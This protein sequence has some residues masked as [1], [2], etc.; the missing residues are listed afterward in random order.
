MISCAN[1]AFREVK[2]FLRCILHEYPAFHICFHIGV[3]LSRYAAR[4][5]VR[6]WIFAG[7]IGRHSRTSSTTESYPDANSVLSLWHNDNPGTTSGDKVGIITTAGASNDDKVDII[8]RTA[9]GVIGDDKF[10]NTI[11]VDFHWGDQESP[12]AIRS[13]TFD[14]P[15][16]WQIYHA[17]PSLKELPIVT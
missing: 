13:G 9:H 2:Y 15:V 12:A 14:N 1:F 4:V 8:P 7:S 10:D 16:H 17:S 6:Y 3:C 5:C 11:T